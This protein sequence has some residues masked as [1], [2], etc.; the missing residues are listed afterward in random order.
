MTK[1]L[2]IYF[3]KYGT[4][5]RYAEWMATDLHADICSAK[6]IKASRLQDYDTII[7]GSALHAG[8]IKSVRMLIKNFDALKNKKLVLYTCGLADYTLSENIAAIAKRLEQT[9]PNHI[10]EHIRFYHLRGGI[11]YRKLG[12]MDK[13]LMRMLKKQVEKKEPSTLSQENREFLATYG[14]IVDFTD[15]ATIKGLVEYCKIE[16]EQY[17]QK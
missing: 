2:V 15:R 8:N 6:K 7:W 5:K 9:I 3:S 4:T 13:F 16:N 1:T 17:K 14:Q 10:R 12:F 11:N